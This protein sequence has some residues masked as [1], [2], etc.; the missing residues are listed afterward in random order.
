MSA[1]RWRENIWHNTDLCGVFGVVSTYI[2][3]IYADFA[4]CVVIRWPGSLFFRWA[5]VILYNALVLLAISSHL[6]CMISNPGTIPFLFQQE[7]VDSVLPDSSNVD[8]PA[9]LA[10]VVRAAPSDCRDGKRTRR[11]CRKCKAPKPPRAHHCSVC[12]YCVMK[13]DH[14]CMWVNNCVA[15]ANQKHFVLFLLYVAIMCVYSIGFVLYRIIAC[16]QPLRS[17]IVHRVPHYKVENLPRH[18]LSSPQ[19]FHQLQCYTTVAEVAIG[20]ILFMTAIVF[21]L[22]SFCAL[23]DQMISILWDESV[24]DQKQ[25]RKGE[26][27]SFYEALSEVCG[28]GISWKWLIP[29]PI[30]VEILKVQ[31][32]CVPQALI[33]LGAQ[34]AEKRQSGSPAPQ[35]STSAE[36][37]TVAGATVRR[38]KD[39][40]VDPLS[41]LTF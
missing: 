27:Q 7:R 13:M 24:I 39:S 6:V 14:H 28:Q 3:L 17:P 8:E 9:T 11:H 23:M 36:T 16:I 35:L 12:N 37:T 20:A 5:H 4:M 32:Y 15:V 22:F 26:S 30:K 38:R 1:S 34:V 10:Q 19:L 2:L 33:G 41:S 21:G 29:L 25:G 18:L 40:A 31:D